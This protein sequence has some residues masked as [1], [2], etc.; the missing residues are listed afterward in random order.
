MHFHAVV[1]HVEC[2]VGH[3]QEVVRE[4]LL[5][6]VALVTAADHEVVHAVGG[7]GLHDVPQD[8][9]ASDFDHRF[10]ASLGFLRDPG[11]QPAGQDDCFHA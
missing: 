5:D 11:A 8:G 7:I 9:P 4:V 6:H 2:H 1:G 3:V 10:G